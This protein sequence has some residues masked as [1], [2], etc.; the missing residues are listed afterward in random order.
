MS[1]VRSTDARGQLLAAHDP[2]ATVWAAE[3]TA[4]VAEAVPGRVVPATPSAGRLVATGDQEG[5]DTIDLKVVRAGAAGSRLEIG[6]KKTTD[7]LYQGVDTPTIPRWSESVTFTTVTATTS[8]LDSPRAVVLDDHRIACVFA[9]YSSAFTSS[10]KPN[11]WITVRSVAGVWSTPEKVFG[12]THAPGSVIPLFVGCPGLAACPVVMNDAAGSVMLYTVT[13]EEVA[14]GAF[15]QVSVIRSTQ[16]DFDLTWIDATGLTQANTEC[17]PAGITTAASDQFSIKVVAHAGQVLLCMQHETSIYQYASTDGGYTFAL[18]GTI[19]GAIPA[20]ILS[21]MD[22]AVVRGVFVLSLTSGSA[23]RVLRV[24]SAFDSFAAQTAI[25]VAALSSDIQ[26]TRLVVTDDDRLWLYVHDSSSALRMIY[27]YFSDDAGAADT[28]VS[29]VTTGGGLIQGARVTQGTA[30]ALTNAGTRGGT[31][32]DVVPHRGRIAMIY[33]TAGATGAVNSVNCTFLG[34][35]ADLVMPYRDEVRNVLS[36]VSWA[37]CWLAQ[38][39]IGDHPVITETFPSGSAGGLAKTFITGGYEQ[40][41]SDGSTV[42]HWEKNTSAMFARGGGVMLGLAA[43]VTGGT[44]TYV[45]QSQNSGNS[46]QVA[47]THTA[48]AVTATDKN[49]AATLGTVSITGP[50]E[51]LVCIRDDVTSIYYRVWAEADGSEWTRLGGSAGLTAA[52][53]LSAAAVYATLAINTTW[54]GAYVGMTCYESSAA[55]RHT[56]LGVGITPSGAA[57]R[58]TPIG[59]Q[60]SPRPQY[61]VDSVYLAA[62]GGPAHLGETWQVAPTSTYAV[63]RAACDAVYPSPRTRWRSSTTT[64]SMVIA[65]QLGTVPES[66]LSASWVVVLE[67]NAPAARLSWH[68]GSSWSSDIVL[69]RHLE[70]SGARAGSIITTA[71]AAGHAT[72]QY[73]DRD[74]LIGGYVDMGSGDVRRIVGNSAGALRCPSG[75]NAALCR[76]RVEGTDETEGAS[77]TWRVVFP[78]SVHILQDSESA[79]K[80]FRIKVTTST[81]SANAPPEGYFEL[82][83]LAGPAWPVPHQHGRDTVRVHRARAATSE[84]ADGTRRTVKLGEP[85]EVVELH[86]ENCPRN[87]S[88]WMIDGATANYFS[89]IQGGSR[90]TA[91]GETMSSLRAWVDARASDGAAVAYIAT[92]DRTVGGGSTINLLTHRQYGAIVGTIDGEWRTQQA[93]HGDEQY[94]EVIRGGTVRIRSL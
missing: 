93:G 74:E 48:S 86:W 68:D 73:V 38:E 13:H 36:R 10:A 6:W 37:S 29:I 30:W 90:D 45:V 20:L 89:V 8:Q 94:T 34:G 11:Y 33:R 66:R 78:R 50:V 15:A 21:S 91:D 75:V 35:A 61:L 56:S 81:D 17:L 77:G 88:D 52:T 55:L 64:D 67:G 54:R 27:T 80:A 57:V 70:I 76:I 49:S 92:Y 44:A 12:G 1:E 87:M 26:T 58:E 72:V 83:I 23:A 53:A 25:N 59:V 62:H 79:K 28:W 43:E 4:D 84:A 51:L 65:Y 40:I 9:G 42:P 14:G 18:V 85:E 7:N 47:V 32:W 82:A 46:Y 5:L 24:A 31:T 71:T 2:R 60:V 69:T 22:L 63:E 19:T 39:H 41:I 16:A 3:T